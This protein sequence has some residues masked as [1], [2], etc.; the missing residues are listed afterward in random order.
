MIL[1]KQ[2]IFSGAYDGPTAVWTGQAP[3]ATAAA[4]VSSTNVIDL[5]ATNTLKDLGTGQDVYLVLIVTTSVDAA[6]G[7]ANITFKL[8]SDSTTNL[9][10]SPTTHWNSGA[11]AKGTLTAGYTKVVELPREKTYERYLGVT[12]TP[13]TNDITS[14]AVLAFLTLDPEVYSTYAKAYTIS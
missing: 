11:I 1:D 12:Y 14:G 9:T 10:T 4:T 7:A 8:V 3:G 6:G 5:T 13:D 2:N